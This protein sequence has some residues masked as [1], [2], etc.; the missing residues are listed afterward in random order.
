MGCAVDCT[1][2]ACLKRPLFYPLNC[3]PEAVVLF[4][5]TVVDCGFVCLLF[6]NMDF[7]C[8][9]VVTNRQHLS[10]ICILTFI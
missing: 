5:L 8:L 3:T 10:H 4:L 9:S 6:F 7:S 1:K 2:Y